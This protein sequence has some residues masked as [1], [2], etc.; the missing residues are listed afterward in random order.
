[1]A[2]SDSLFENKKLY[3]LRFLRAQWDGWLKMFKTI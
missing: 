1:V 2:A 3:F